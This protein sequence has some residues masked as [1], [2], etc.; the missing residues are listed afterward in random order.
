[1]TSRTTGGQ[2]DEF[3]EYRLVRLGS[4]LERRF[5]S[6]LAPTGLS[7]RQFSVLAVLT[8]SPG[9]TSADLA[10]AVLTTPQSMGPL[11]DQMESRGLVERTKERGRGRAAPVRVTDTGTALLHEAARL[12]GTLDAAARQRLGEQGHQELSRLLAVLEDHVGEA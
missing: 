10:R 2:P 7:P 6:A 12:V 5:A 9:I 8:E 11:L 3:L 4:R 1:M